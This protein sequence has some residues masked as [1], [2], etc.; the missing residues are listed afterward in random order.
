MTARDLADELEALERAATPGP[1]RVSEARHGW[2]AIIRSEDNDPVA[3]VFL[4]GWD[5]KSAT[6]HAAL[7][8][9]LRNAAPLL[10]AALRVAEAEY[11]QVAMLSGADLT[12]ESFI[13]SCGLAAQR[14]HNASEGYRAARDA[15]EKEGK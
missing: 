7:I 9:A 11:Q 4:A 8:A 13:L 2:D 15:A 10:V 6:A 12:D 5:K 14:A 1:W 3:S